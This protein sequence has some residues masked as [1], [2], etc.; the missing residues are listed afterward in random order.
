MIVKTEKEFNYSEEDLKDLISCAVC[1]GI[2]Y[3][4]IIDNTTIEWKEHKKQAGNEATFEDIFFNILKDGKTVVIED[5]ESDDVWAINAEKLQKGIKM[6]IE[7]GYWS[8]DVDDADGE[9]GDVVFQYALFGEI[10]FG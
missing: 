1:G 9:T 2:D 4:G 3:W 6:T 5:I 7:N 10:V 8:G